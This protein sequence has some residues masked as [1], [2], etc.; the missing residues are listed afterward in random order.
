MTEQGNTGVPTEEQEVMVHEKIVLHK[1]EGNPSQE[2]IDNGAAAPVE[3][4]VID[5]GK[6]IE[7]TIH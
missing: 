3:T 4:V 5:Q 1:Y 2:D 7:H 6:I